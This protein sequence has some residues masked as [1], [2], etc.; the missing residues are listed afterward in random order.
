MVDRE[1][2]Y[3]Q[4]PNRIVD[5]NTFLSM[6]QTFQELE[7]YIDSFGRTLSDNERRLQQ[8]LPGMIKAFN[9][10]EK[11]YRSG[12][13]QLSG[14][15]A[16]DLKVMLANEQNILKWL[17]DLSKFG[18]D[19]L[20]RNGRGDK[21]FI[22][23]ASF[24]NDILKKMSV[25][26][27]RAYVQQEK[28]NRTVEKTRKQYGL[29]PLPNIN[30]AQQTNS[31]SIASSPNATSIVIPVSPPTIKEAISDAFG[32]SFFQ[33]LHKA[34]KE[35]PVIGSLTGKMNKVSQSYTGGVEALNSSGVITGALD[36][37]YDKF[38]KEYDSLAAL[39][40]LQKT[41]REAGS[42]DKGL[43]KQFKDYGFFTGSQSSI[44][45]PPFKKVFAQ[46]SK[47]GLLSGGMAVT[48]VAS[49][50]L[51]AIPIIGA[52]LT[53]VSIIYKQMKKSS[54]VLQAVSSLFELAWNL[55]W[56]PLGNALG[57]LLLPM[58]EDL[59]NFAILFNELFTDF[60][61]E[62]LGELFYAGFQFI[63]GALFD[64]SNALPTMLID[65]LLTMLSEFY[66]SIGLDGI[67]DGINGIKGF[68][69][70]MRDLI[71]NLPTSIYNAFSTLWTFIKDF[72]SEFVNK[73]GTWF[74]SQL[75]SIFDGIGDVGGKVADWWDSVSPF[76]TGGIVTSPTLGL[77]GEA[78]P[79]A[80]IPLDKANGIG[81]SYVINI[82]GD[83]YG[84]SDLESRIER[85]IQRTANKAYYR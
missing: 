80:I 42:Y 68:I 62:K 56:M 5:V 72:F 83:V 38:K 52:I 73:V 61:W 4:V 16:A 15:Q 8:T 67:A 46:K 74:M 65:G 23:Y 7:R 85:A 33:S 48:K 12:N 41:T 51:K 76:A 75:R 39:S 40:R 34:L 28:Y 59:I 54:P 63:W 26:M 60:S 36:G 2:K 82:N 43:R 66:R 81:T 84:V 79:E 50:A 20:S 35:V 78:G 49:V 37:L 17:N 45:H 57:T 10:V 55:L 3:G 25:S 71:R 11:E 77:V 32:T 47:M 69:S 70:S 14:S 21:S 44:S 18:K 6:N 1:S 27:E 53:G 64:I 31:T 19:G 9:R 24:F 30:S 22:Q 58:A 29:V 13:G